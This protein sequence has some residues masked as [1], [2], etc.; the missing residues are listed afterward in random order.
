MEW[1]KS[2]REEQISN[3]NTHVIYEISKNGT[4]EPICREGI[5]MQMWRMDSWN[6]GEGEGGVNWETGA[7][8]YTLSCVKHTHDRA[9]HSVTA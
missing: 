3:I 5:G 4:D 7:D 1:S 2:E 9:W 8:I 6:S